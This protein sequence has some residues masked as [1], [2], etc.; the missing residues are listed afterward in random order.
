MRLNIIR[1][2][3]KSMHNINVRGASQIHGGVVLVKQTNTH[4]HTYCIGSTNKRNS[5]FW[6]KSGVAFLSYAVTPFCGVLLRR[7][8]YT[9]TQ[10]HR[11]T[12]V[13][14]QFLRQYYRFMLVVF[15]V[16]H[17]PLHRYNETQKNHRCTIFLHTLIR[18]CQFR[19][20]TCTV[21]AL[22]CYT[23]V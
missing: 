20:N 5:T 7:S 23:S 18:A 9:A 8:V 15:G 3:R 17:A 12:V 19:C 16:S 14:R 6:G 22:H 21:T 2:A 10:L 1:D 4:K 13:P 11:C